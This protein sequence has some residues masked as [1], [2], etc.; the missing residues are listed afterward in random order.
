MVTTTTTKRCEMCKATDGRWHAR[1]RINP[2]VTKETSGSAHHS[3]FWTASVITHV[4]ASGMCAVCE[5]IGVDS[6][7]RGDNRTGDLFGGK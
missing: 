6:A 3:Q 2:T 1:S 4:R 5:Q 7:A